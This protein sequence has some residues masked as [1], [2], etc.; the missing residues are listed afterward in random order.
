M[1]LTADRLKM[2]APAAISLTQPLTT[3]D[4]LPTP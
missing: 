1:I 3:V 2:D 4:A